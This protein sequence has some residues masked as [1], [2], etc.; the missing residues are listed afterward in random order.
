MR[1][2]LSLLGSLVI[3][4]PVYLVLRGVADQLGTLKAEIAELEDREKNLRDELIRRGG[5][6]EGAVYRATIADAVRWTLDAKTVR[7]EMGEPWWNA[8]CRQALVTTVA[9]KVLAVAS[10]LAA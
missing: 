10:K 2:R 4:A 8:R 3:Y 5:K 6:I 7:S 9:V 1:R